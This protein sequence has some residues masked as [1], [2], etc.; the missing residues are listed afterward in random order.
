MTNRR[1]QRSRCALWVLFA[2]LVL[3]ALVPASAGAHAFLVSSSPPQGSRLARAPRVVTLRFSEP[4]VAGGTRITV[5]RANGS[6]V[7]T[8]A[9]TQAGALI[10]QALPAALQGVVVVSWRVL[11]DD[12]HLTE[13][14][15]AFAVGSPG[16]LPAISSRTVARTPPEAVAL[17]LLVFA[18]L[19]LA[20]GGAVSERVIWRPARTAGSAPVGAG[21]ALALVGALGQLVLIAGERAGGGFTAGLAPGALGVIAGTRPGALTLVIVAAVV[22]AAGALGLRRRVL[23]IPALAPGLVAVSLR[24]H[25]GTSGHAWAVLADVLHL[26]GAAVWV[27]ALTHLALVVRSDRQSDEVAAAIR[28]YS[29]LA[30]PTVLVILVAGALDALAELTS[31]ADLVTTDYGR[32]LLVKG[33]VIAVALGLAAGSRWRAL[34]CNPTIRLALLRRLT[35]LELVALL[36]VLVVV[37][38]LVNAAPPRSSAQAAGARPTRLVLG[39]PPLRG[40]TLELG[41]LAGLGIDVGLTASADELRFQVLKIDHPAPANTRLKVTATGVGRTAD[42][43]PRRCGAGCFDLHYRLRPGTTTLTVNV[44]IPRW[45]SGATRLRVPWPPVSEQPGLLTHVLR[46][47]EHVPRVVVFEHDSSG[48]GAVARPGTY[49]MSGRTFI[50]QEPYTAGAVD[51]RPLE[52]RRPYRRIAFALPG[53]AIWVQMTIDDLY[54]IR[55]ETIVAPGHLIRRTFSYPEPRGG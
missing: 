37:A 50:A 43:F 29:S 17:S 14:E 28:R 3:V 34:P 16:A 36:A 2:S 48:A 21:L 4:V 5:R 11:A 42:L 20:L 55:R 30:L 51:V 46:S 1:W 40:P 6:P 7:P 10:R 15:F 38:L 9:P 52:R 23:A 39:P 22:A 18:G 49:Q 33:A 26:T 31:P 54:R 27:G 24:S 25:A 53:S 35:R 41:G 44:E 12:G 32:T 45:P 47:M 19:A 8:A 13:G